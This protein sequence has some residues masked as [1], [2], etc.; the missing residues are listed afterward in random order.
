M[1]ESFFLELELR[2]ASAEEAISDDGKP[3][4]FNDDVGDRSLWRGATEHDIATLRKTTSA[5][6]HWQ[7]V[8]GGIIEQSLWY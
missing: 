5:L 6:L 3:G 7:R 2:E 4:A 8:I 1:R